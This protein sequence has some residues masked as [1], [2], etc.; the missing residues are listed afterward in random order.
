MQKGRQ[1]GR[2]LLRQHR[3]NLRSGVD[4]GGVAAGVIVDRGAALHECV[5]VR[6]CNQNLDRSL[7]KRLGD[8]ELV[9][10]ARIVIVDG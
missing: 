1:I 4:G 6:N 7:R 5:D 9:Q 3:K 10:I 2:E 8:G